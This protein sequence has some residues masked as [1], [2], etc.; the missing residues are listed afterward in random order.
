M[1][2][3]KTWPLIPLEQPLMS[4]L[5]PHLQIPPQQ[6]HWTRTLKLLLVRSTPSP[7][8]NI[9]L[10]SL[11]LSQMCFLKIGSQ[12]SVKL[13]MIQ[14]LLLLT[15]IVC[16]VSWQEVSCKEIVSNH[17]RSTWMSS[18]TKKK[19]QQSSTCYLEGAKS[20]RSSMMVFT[21]EDSRSSKPFSILIK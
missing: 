13:E 8:P 6:I 16:T 5:L 20:Q 10:W 14:S 12:P 4:P 2:D 15:M 1:Q 17:L 7:R 11:I 9:T 18:Q 19:Q 3:Q 21:L